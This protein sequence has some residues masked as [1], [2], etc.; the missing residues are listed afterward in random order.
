MAVSNEQSLDKDSAFV[1]DVFASPEFSVFKAAKQQLI[2]MIDYF[3]TN[4]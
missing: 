4:A 2:D 3:C 1:R